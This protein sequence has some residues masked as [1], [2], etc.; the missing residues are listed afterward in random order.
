M[1]CSD[2][3]KIPDGNRFPIWVN[4]YMYRENGKLFY[5]FTTEVICGFTPLYQ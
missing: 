1:I 2:M 4:F 3:K 5:A